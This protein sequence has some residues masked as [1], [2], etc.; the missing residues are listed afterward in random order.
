MPEMLQSSWQGSPPYCGYT[1]HLS[2][3]ERGWNPYWCWLIDHMGVVEIRQTFHAQNVFVFIQH[4]QP[5][6]LI[7]D[8]MEV[9]SLGKFQVF[10]QWVQGIEV[11]QRIL[12][13]NTHFG[14]VWESQGFFQLVQNELESMGVHISGQASA[15][16]SHTAGNWRGNHYR[17]EWGVRKALIGSHKT[18]ASMEETEQQP[19]RKT[20]FSGSKWAP[21]LQ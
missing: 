20:K 18:V 19:F 14:Q 16:L 8:D 15:Q 17:R 2:Q 10:L 4:R 6:N 13:I 9:V 7:Y 11:I 5:V 3:S 21:D 1:E 12:R